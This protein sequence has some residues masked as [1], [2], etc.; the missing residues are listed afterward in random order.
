MRVVNRCTM[1]MGAQ[2]WPENEANDNEKP[3]HLVQVSSFGIGVTEV[4]QALWQAV[5][6]SNPSYFMGN[7]NRPVESVS[8]KDCQQFITKLN[9][10]TGRKFRLP[11]EA[12]W[13][14]AASAGFNDISY[15]NHASMY[16]GSARIDNVAWYYDNSYAVGIGDPN[17]GTH[18]VATKSAN[19]LGLYDMSGNVWEWCQD[20]YVAYNDEPQCNPTGPAT[21]S[22]RVMRGGS[23][24]N[25]AKYSR[26][27]CRNYNDP[28]YAEYHVGL[29]LALD[30]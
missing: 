30:L 6:G 7:L 10:L 1:M 25:S 26:V 14:Y 15:Y 8:W 27:S 4:T 17:Y 11:T 23:W 24:C 5:M 21:G 19:S 16:S 12:E 2:D 3:P 13:E 22:Y 18:S 28:D 29:R 9:E 20:W